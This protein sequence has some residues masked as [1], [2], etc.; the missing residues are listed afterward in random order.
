MEERAADGHSCASPAGRSGQMDGGWLRGATSRLMW[1]MI[2]MDWPR[3]EFVIYGRAPNG[4]SADGHATEE[5]AAGRAADGSSKGMKGSGAGLQPV[6]L[7]VPQ[8]DNLNSNLDA[9][10]TMANND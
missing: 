7:T 6:Q 10:A 2:M 9:V 1:I 5:R 4:R 8:Q 3:M